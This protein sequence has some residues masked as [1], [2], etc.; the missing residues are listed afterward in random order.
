[1]AD[2][3]PEKRLF[4]SLLTRDIPLVAAFLDLID[5]SVNAAVE[6]H[7][8][9]LKTA[10]DYIQTFQ[11]PELV[12]EVEISIS[13]SDNKV[14]IKDNAGGISAG[15]AA[16]H[17]FK[18]GRSEEEESV[19]DRLS[20]YGIGLKRALFKLGNKIRMQSDHVEGGFDLDLDVAKWAKIKTQPWNFPITTREMV[21]VGKTG[22]TITISDLYDDVKR[23]INDGIFE[24]ELR[25]AIARTYAYYLAKFVRIN[26]GGTFV[27][28]DSLEVGSNVASDDFVSGRVTCAITAGIGQSVGGKFRERSSGWF[29][30]CNGRGVVSADKTQLTGWGS[31]LG[32][33]LF[34]PK[35]RPFLG[36]VFFVSER[37]DLLPWTTTKSGINEDSA[38]WQEAK[39]HMAT[40]GR[41]VVSFLDSRYTDEG[42]EIASKDV[43]EAAGERVSAITAAVVT[44]RTFEL[45]KRPAPTTVRVQYDAKVSDVKRVEQYL[46]RPGM[47]AAEVG[48]H[49]FHFF[50]KNEVGE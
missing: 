50:L 17:V 3:S 15:T 43:Q 31:G 37:A 18:F 21:A 4:I 5:N 48:R 12:P 6:P 9:R 16:E 44:K 24:G 28:G 29:V 8:G 35:H 20:V 34:Q 19:E 42:T 45:P 14:I 39:R 27:E 10:S 26:V 32:L 47:G 30:F 13:I 23:R 22:T 11:D 25:E 38:V 36:T 1:M 46:R 7:A 49:T 2:A 40:V 41:L 33:P